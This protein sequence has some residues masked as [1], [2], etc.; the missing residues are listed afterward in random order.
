[1]PRKAKI[2]NFELN[3]CYVPQKKVENIYN[4]DY[5]KPGKNL[6]GA[7]PMIFTNMFLGVSVP[8]FRHQSS[9]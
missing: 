3:K 6:G 8:S 5:G 2:S 7:L 9:K 4:K 1:M